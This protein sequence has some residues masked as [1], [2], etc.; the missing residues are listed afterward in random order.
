[1]FILLI[2]SY[3]WLTVDLQQTGRPDYATPEKRWIITVLS[4]SLQHISTSNI[5][6]SKGQLKEEAVNSIAFPAPHG[7]LPRLRPR[8]QPSHPDALF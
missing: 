3:D 7:R 1:M 2:A 8:Q 5:S 6:T 4:D